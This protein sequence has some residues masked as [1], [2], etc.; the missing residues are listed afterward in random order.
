MTKMPKIILPVILILALLLTSCSAGSKTPD[1]ESPTVPVEGTKV[2]NIA[3]DFQLQNLEGQIVSLAS[4]RGKP[5]LINFWTSL[6]SYCLDEM[7]D[8]QDIYEE[9]SD[10]GLVLLM[11]NKGE[12]SSKV[13]EVMQH[14]R[15][16]ST[17]L[18]DT[19]QA[20]AQ[21]YN[22]QYNPTTFFIDKDGIIQDRVNGAFLNKTQ[23]ENKL[24]KIMP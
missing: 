16:S 24:T 23:I 1:E 4:L 5:V 8:I 22:I 3:P 9:W 20:I 6:C 2:G 19:T 14:Y 13:E 7:P 12:S 15:L 21:K 11:I 17:V 10:K 18:L